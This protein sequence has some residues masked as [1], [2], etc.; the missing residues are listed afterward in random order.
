[1]V[2][3]Q[4]LRKTKE[5]VKK[6]TTRIKTAKIK[7]KK[8]I[9]MIKMIKTMM[10]KMMMTGMMRTTTTMMTTTM[11][12]ITMMMMMTILEVFLLVLEDQARMTMMTNKTR[13][14]KINKSRKTKR[15]KRK[16]RRKTK[17]KIESNPKGASHKKNH[18]QSFRLGQSLSKSSRQMGILTKLQILYKNLNKKKRSMKNRKKNLEIGLK[19]KSLK[20][21]RNINLKANQKN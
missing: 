9:K 4:S 13:K 10:T 16:N 8:M 18:S 5:I 17:I 1:M 20:I 21:D 14:N 6:K 12:M 7:T 15:I 2:V 11:M 19:T 3:T